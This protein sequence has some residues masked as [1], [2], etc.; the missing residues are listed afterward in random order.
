M[1]MMARLE[2]VVDGHGNGS[3]FATTAAKARHGPL[4]VGVLARRSGNHVRYRLA[5]PGNR[6]GLAVLN[7][8]EELGQTRLGLGR[9]YGAHR[10]VQPVAVTG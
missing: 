7:R 8:P 5:T 10:K 3:P 2:N 6:H 1:A 9:L 4:A